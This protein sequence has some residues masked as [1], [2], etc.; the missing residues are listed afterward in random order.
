MASAANAP[1]R[2][3]WR[4]AASFAASFMVPPRLEPQRGH[5]ST[6]PAKAF[7][8]GAFTQIPQSV[9]IQLVRLA[10]HD[11]ES[12]LCE[13]K[14]TMPVQ[15]GGSLM[16]GAAPPPQSD[17]ASHIARISALIMSAHFSPIMIDGAL[18]LPPIK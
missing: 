8:L 7:Y 11:N 14:L 12:P 17:Y 13:R 2:A 9:R 10:T 6:L 15:C 3:R 4:S 18:V 16:R 1:K 5:D